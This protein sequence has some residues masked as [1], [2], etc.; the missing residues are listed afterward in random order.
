MLSFAI[1]GSEILHAIPLSESVAA[2]L[3]VR[4]NK[5]MGLPSTTTESP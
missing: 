4:V 1:I 2:M 5:R 3:K